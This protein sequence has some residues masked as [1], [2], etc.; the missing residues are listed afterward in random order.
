MGIFLGNLQSKTVEIVAS[1]SLDYTNTQ[2]I[3]SQNLILGGH[4]KE[5]FSD[6]KLWFFLLTSSLSVGCI[7]HNRTC[8]RYHAFNQGSLPLIISSWWIDDTSPIDNTHV[9]PRSPAVTCT[10]LSLFLAHIAFRL[11]E[12]IIEFKSCYWNTSQS[13]TIIG[14]STLF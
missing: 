4:D 3:Q 13:P 14:L 2:C 10:M 11:L 8:D 6:R 12:P 7:R 5:P 1:F 9:C